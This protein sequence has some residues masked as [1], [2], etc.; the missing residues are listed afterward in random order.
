MMLFIYWAFAWVSPEACL[1]MM[2]TL[3]V[4]WLQIQRG[5]LACGRLAEGVAGGSRRLSLREQPVPWEITGLAVL[6]CISNSQAWI[7]PKTQILSKLGQKSSLKFLRGKT[8][9]ELLTCWKVGL[10][11]ALK[12]RLGQ[13]CFVSDECRHTLI[14]SF[15]NS[16][17]TVWIMRSMW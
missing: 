10:W 15:L 2:F 6:A 13:L 8:N 9:V 3:F 12:L 7:S 11:V 4:N 17:F 1:C 14:W 16:C 5:L